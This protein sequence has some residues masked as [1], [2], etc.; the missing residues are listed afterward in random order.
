MGS[1]L[2]GPLAENKRICLGLGFRVIG[3]RLEREREREYEVAGIQQC[4]WRGLFIAG[5]P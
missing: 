3:V 5:L 4:H 1:V 2:E